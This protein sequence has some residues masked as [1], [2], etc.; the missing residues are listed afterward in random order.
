MLLSWNH[1]KC[2]HQR[3]LILKTKI[4]KFSIQQLIPMLAPWQYLWML[5]WDIDNLT[6]FLRGRYNE[7]MSWK[8]SAIISWIL[9]ISPILANISILL[10]NNWHNKT[11]CNWNDGYNTI[12]QCCQMSVNF[13]ISFGCHRFYQKT[14]DFFSGFLP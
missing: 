12:P 13:E 8:E 4:G 9:Y 2:Y 10:N 11:Y 1:L 7:R 3:I 14:N 6:S 5:L